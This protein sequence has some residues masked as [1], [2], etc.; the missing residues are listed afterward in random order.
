MAN[1]LD[2]A[3][4]AYGVEGGFIIEFVTS[5]TTYEAW[6]YHESEGI[7]TLMFGVDKKNTDYTKFQKMVLAVQDEYIEDYK[8]TIM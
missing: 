3:Y 2:L 8:E 4:Q 5:P 6:L 7:K 1:V